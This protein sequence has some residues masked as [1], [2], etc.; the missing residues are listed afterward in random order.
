VQ[1]AGATETGDAALDVWRAVAA[2]CAGASTVA[3]ATLF[4]AGVLY[5][6]AQFAAASVVADATLRNQIVTGLLVVWAAVWA[7][8]MTATSASAGMTATGR[9][10]APTATG[11]AAGITGT[12]A[13]PAI[14][15]TGDG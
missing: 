7:G 4:T 10:I 13:G 15:A 9:N 5:M 12:G 1:M 2:H 8:G 6:Q 3:D 11:R 14:V